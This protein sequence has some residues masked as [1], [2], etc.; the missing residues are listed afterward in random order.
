[1]KFYIK[2]HLYPNVGIL[3]PSLYDNDN[4]RNLIYISRLKNKI[5][6]VSTLKHREFAQGDACFDFVVG[7]CLFMRKDFF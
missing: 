5:S 7:C 2:F 6:R 3:A 1:M 4:Q